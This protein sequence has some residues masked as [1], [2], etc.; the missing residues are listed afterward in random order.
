M[1]GVPNIGG[2][3]PPPAPNPDAGQQG[4]S[5]GV[6]SA[7]KMPSPAIIPGQAAAQMPGQAPGQP[8]PMPQPAA[9]THGQTVAVLRHMDAIQAELETILKDPAAGKSNLKRK[10]IDG[11]AKLVA[12]R[13]ITPGAAVAQ[14]AEVPDNPFQQRRWL[15][16]HLI[17]TIVAKVKVLNDHQ[18]AFAGVPENMIDKTSSPDNHLSDMAAVHSAYGG[19]RG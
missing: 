9:P 18:Q 6:L 11:T 5:N 16:Q 2:S 14:L 4:P 10:I 12:D 17:Q 19:G 1:A 7:P 15:Q 13:I 8:Q 3:G